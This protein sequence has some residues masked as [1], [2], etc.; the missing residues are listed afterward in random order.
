MR[1]PFGVLVA[2]L[3]VGLT[4]APAGAAAPSPAP[5]DAAR[6]AA[7]AACPATVELYDTEGRPLARPLPR[8]TR[9][10]V[11]I[12]AG[13]PNVLV[14]GAHDLNRT[15]ELV[16]STPA[17]ET[18]P[19]LINVET[20]LLDDRFTWFV[21]RV[22]SIG[23]GLPGELMWHFPTAERVLLLGPR[24]PGVIFAPG[25]DVRIAPSPPP[26][27]SP[28][29]PSPS[30]VPSPAVSASPPVGGT[31]PGL[32]GGLP[33]G[34]TPA[35]FAPRSD[36]APDAARTGT[37]HHAVLVAHL[38]VAPAP[39]ARFPVELSCGSSPSPSAVPS[40]SASLPAEPSAQAPGGAVPGPAASPTPET[41]SA[42]LA[43][44][45]SRPV[46]WFG[47]ALLLAGLALVV[48][49]TAG[50]RAFRRNY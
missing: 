18:S 33:P 20:S 23:G 28:V 29:P 13:R 16:L 40:P 25:A 21:P 42:H 31:A 19:L 47:V 37:P 49:I 27:P 9:L 1:G 50:R 35:A 17:T 41:V 22:R 46:T 4:A 2:L 45:A 24:P 11:D 15:V 10:L 44:L 3:L 48:W 34:W 38:A 36:R 5:W 26:S 14:L 43:A 30:P 39:A 12:V 7:L 6:S 32:P 8:G